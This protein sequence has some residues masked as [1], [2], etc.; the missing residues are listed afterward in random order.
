[1]E[2]YESAVIGQPRYVY[3]YTPPG[4]D[5]SRQRYPVL[6]LMHGGNCCET[7][8]TQQV[9]ANVILDNLI[10]EGRA[11]PMIVVMPLGARSGPSDYLA[12]VPAQMEGAPAGPGG[13]AGA[14]SNY[15]P[16][17]LFEQDLLRGIIPFIDQKY[18]TLADADHRGMSGLSQGGIQS[19]TIGLRHTDVFHWVAP[20]SAGAES[21]GDDQF[22]GPMKDVYENPGPVK[23][24]LKLL[25][26]TVGAED[27]LYEA[28]RRLVERLRAGGVNLTFVPIPGRHQYSVWR[29]GLRDLAP[30]LF[31]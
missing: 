21:Q 8:W 6:Y 31:R 27:V 14:Q 9:R 10:A 4:Y 23:R 12:P 29:R 5:Q 11:K 3:V 17:N 28:D 1:M 13:A 26:V 24:N 22:I 7:A 15:A 16:N 2:I 18:R 25:Y 20:M 30:L 19:F